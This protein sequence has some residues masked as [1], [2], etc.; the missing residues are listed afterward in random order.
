MR[1]SR[2]KR[3]TR[4]RNSVSKPKPARASSP[5][6]RVGKKEL[7]PPLTIDVMYVVT[8]CTMVLADIELFQRTWSARHLA[9]NPLPLGMGEYFRPSN[10][11]AHNLFEE[12]AR[13]PSEKELASLPQAKLD[14]LISGL[15]PIADYWIKGLRAMSARV[16]DRDRCRRMRDDYQGRLERNQPPITAEEEMAKAGGFQVEVHNTGDSMGS[17]QV[18]AIVKGHQSRAR[19][20]ISGLDVLRVV[21]PELLKPISEATAKRSI[22]YSREGL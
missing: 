15:S 8:A 16:N 14:E 6:V 1:K 22:K 9:K 7:I 19:K 18:R 21:A 20:T 17:R 11:W 4:T 3:N 5:H 13:L 2:P 12:L 10:Y